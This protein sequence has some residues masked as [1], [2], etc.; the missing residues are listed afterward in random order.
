MQIKTKLYKGEVEMVFDSFKHTY[1]VTDPDNQVFDEKM[2]SA[3]TV[4]GIIAKPQLI[5]WAANITADTIK[6]QLS[7][8]V[9]L[10]E[11]QI[12]SIIE[13]GRRAHT[14]RKKDAGSMGTLVHKWVEDYIKGEAPAQPVNKQLQ[15]SIA[16]FLG[17]VEKHQVKFVLSEQQVYSRKYGYT[18]TLDFICY[19]DGK[20]YIGDLK[21]TSGIYPEMLIQTSAYRYARTEEFP[22]EKYE[23]QIIVR[24]GKD[25]GDLEIGVLTDTVWYKRM[26]ADFLYA[27][28]LYKGMEQIKEFKV[29]KQIR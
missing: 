11:L 25:N 16:K 14:Q 17:W 12:D 18:G 5:Y 29:E 22:E 15:I 8:G 27:L 28:Q 24:V 23:G 19:I 4:L 10:D 26:L 1:M 2:P 20:M 3:T 13:T 6:E 7:A 21:T 9:A